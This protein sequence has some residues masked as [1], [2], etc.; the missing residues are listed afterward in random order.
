MSICDRCGTV[1]EKMRKSQRFCSNK[2][3]QS[4]HNAY[5]PMA[6]PVG[7]LVMV[8]KIKTG[9]VSMTIHF[10]SDDARR[11]LEFSV[12]DVLLVATDSSE[13]DSIQSK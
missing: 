6:G 11:A 7:A 3:R 2:C 9:A 10:K 5:K 8:R 13:V 12:G 4:F 1:Y